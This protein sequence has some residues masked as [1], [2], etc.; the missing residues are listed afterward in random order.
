MENKRKIKSNLLKLLGVGVLASL[1]YVFCTGCEPLDSDDGSD[2]EETTNAYTSV[3]S[4]SRDSNGE[5]SGSRDSGNGGSLDSFVI[6]AEKPI[7]Y[8]SG[9]IISRANA[10]NSKVLHL[11]MGGQANYSHDFNTGSK[12]NLV[13]RYSNDDTGAGDNVNVLANGEK[14]GSFHTKDTGNN[15]AGWDIFTSSPGIT[16]AASQKN[17]IVSIEVTSSDG[18]GVDFDKLSFNE[19]GLGAV[20][21][22]ASSNE[23]E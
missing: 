3:S 2:I 19:M 17:L 20:N 18:Y 8:T 23:T 13:V 15:G 22:T 4:P 5:D 1:P 11:D 6:E 16:F 14:I 7:S 10:S 9:M 21:D 12:Y